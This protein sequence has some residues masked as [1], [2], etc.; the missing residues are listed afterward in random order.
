MQEDAMATLGR[1][2]IVLSLGLGASFA[3]GLAAIAGAQTPGSKTPPQI[4]KPPVAAKPA[5]PAAPTAAPASGAVTIIC[6]DFRFGFMPGGVPSRQVNVQYES[7]V[8]RDAGGNSRT[9]YAPINVVVGH[10]FKPMTVAIGADGSGLTSGYCG[11]PGA[12]VTG[13]TRPVLSFGG[14]RHAGATT[15]MVPGDPTSSGS[16]ALPPCA[17]GLRRFQTDRQAPG[18]FFVAGDASATCIGG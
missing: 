14:F 9:I 17:S 1:G 15:N 6:K 12:V 16:V 11:T 13:A 18:V 10:E 8:M 7:I 3:L 2:R 5:T 4:G